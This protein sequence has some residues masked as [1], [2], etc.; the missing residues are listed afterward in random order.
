[1]LEVLKALVYL[2]SNG[3]A[4]RDLKPENILYSSSKWKLADFGSSN[5]REKISKETVCGTPEYIAPEMILKAGHDEKVDIWAFGIV[6]YELLFGY[7]PFAPIQTN[8]SENSE[9]EVFNQ[10]MQNTLVDFSVIPVF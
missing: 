10:L 2:H 1:M 7:T 3:I 8:N 4:H 6:Y 9:S 5:Y